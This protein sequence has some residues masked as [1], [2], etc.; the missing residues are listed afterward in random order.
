MAENLVDDIDDDL[1]GVESPQDS[2]DDTTTTTDTT[3]ED[4]S[5]EQTDFISQLLKD[6]GIEDKS[7]IQFEEDGVIKNVNWDDLTDQD[8]LNIIRTS[9]PVQKSNSDDLDQAE[10]SLINHIRESGMSPSEYIDYATAQA[11]SN[12][13]NDNSVPQYSID[14]YDDDSLYIADFM[15]RI[16]GS[17]EEEA[18]EALEQAKSNE[19]LWKR[20]IESIRNQYK[21]IEDETRM[22]Q[23]SEQDA[24]AQ[25]RFN[26]FS[27]QVV[28]EINGLK[29]YSGYDL[30]LQD[31]DMQEIYDFITS[32][33]AAGNN[34]FAKA[35]ADPKILVRTAWLTLHGE[36]MLD[37]ITD[38]YQKAIT[39]AR[40][41]GY[42]KGLKDNGNRKPDVV[43]QPKHAAKGAEI[44][45][46]LDDF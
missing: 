44:Y 7:Q 11:I 27:D 2:K 22:Q 14:Q 6:R 25:E 29:T 32:T 35:L 34:Y 19:D 4:N 39:K 15:S 46:D 43:Y 20:Q 24:I 12:Y 8:K 36:D 41:E 16:Q 38:Y 23:Q 31:D 1:D 10:L 17:T 18:R 13:Q 9:S 30:N 21:T 5:G 33:D 37:D 26:Q 40:Q 28:N 45:D 42:E 3:P